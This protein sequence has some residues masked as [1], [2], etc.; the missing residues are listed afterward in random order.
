GDGLRARPGVSLAGV[1]VGRLV[2]G[3]RRHRLCPVLAP[4]RAVAATAG[5]GGA[6][7]PCNVRAADGPRRPA[8]PV[9]RWRP[10]LLPAAPGD[11]AVLF[12]V[13][14][15]GPPDGPC[16]RADASPGPRGRLPRGRLGRA[17]LGRTPAGA[18]RRRPGG[19]GTGRGP[20]GAG[21]GGAAALVPR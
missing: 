10:T 1:D 18:L 7:G 11:R 8:R 9:E 17:G 13:R 16:R 14:T 12:S 6:P 2:A 19:P 20:G 15:A 4:A 3:P 5:A 21:P